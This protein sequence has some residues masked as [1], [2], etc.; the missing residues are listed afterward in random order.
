VNTEPDVAW[1]AGGGA[2]AH[3][4]ALVCEPD[5]CIREVLRDDLG[6]APPG[7]L[8]R[9]LAERVDPTLLLRVADFFRRVRARGAAFG[10]ECLVPL[11]GG[12][13]VLALSGART[14]GRLLVFLSAGGAPVPAFEQLVRVN[15]EQANLLRTTAKA[16]FEA[17]R[18]GATR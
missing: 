18:G 14:G 13:A 9:P 7:A 8:G 17:S 15:N 16:L 5:G 12:P 1:G 2:E 11:P 10:W 6:V 4:A 3:G